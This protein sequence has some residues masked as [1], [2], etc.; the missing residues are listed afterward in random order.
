VKPVAD[1]TRLELAGF[2]AAEFQR[3]NIN[4]VLSGGSCV[5]IYSQCRRQSGYG[6][7]APV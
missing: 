2:I 1:M 4:V 5:S 7:D 6:S 3:R